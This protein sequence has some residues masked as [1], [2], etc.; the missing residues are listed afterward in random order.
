[1]TL[2]RFLYTQRNKTLYFNHKAIFKKLSRSG[3]Y[4]RIISLKINNKDMV[5]GI[6]RDIIE[7]KKRDENTQETENRLRFLT[8]RLIETRENECKRIALELHD[9]MGQALTAA[10]FNLSRLGNDIPESCRELL[11]DTVSI[12]DNLSDQIRNLSL[13]LRPSMLDDL[14]LIPTVRWYLNRFTKRTGI[15]TALKAVGLDDYRNETLEITIYRVVQE[16]LNNVLKHATAKNVEISLKHENSRFT[17]FIQDDGKGF[18]INK[19]FEANDNKHVGLLSMKERL[20]LLGGTFEIQS[21]KT[22]GTRINIEIPLNF[23]QKE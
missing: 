8:C 9:E 3:A 6:M 11:A 22:R 12:V 1:M 7:R 21:G 15:K 14:G 4:R 13:D 23:V 2:I 19:I 16:S 5:F 18:D 10:S 20:F 17:G